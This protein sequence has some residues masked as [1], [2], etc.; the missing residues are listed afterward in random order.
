VLPVP[1][2]SGGAVELRLVFVTGHELLVSG[3]AIELE[4]L[5]KPTYVEEFAARE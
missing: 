3:D 2:Q 1:L 4:L 5:R